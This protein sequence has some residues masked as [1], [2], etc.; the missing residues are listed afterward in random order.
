MLVLPSEGKN[1][2]ELLSLFSLNMNIQKIKF[3]YNYIKRTF[4]K[5]NK[6]T[7][8]NAIRTLSTQSESCILQQPSKAL[9][10]WIPKLHPPILTYVV[11]PTAKRLKDY[12]SC[13]R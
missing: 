6:K 4:F 3:L 1:G 7:K 8:T 10:K 9:G 11:K 13:L 2:F 12:K 5:K